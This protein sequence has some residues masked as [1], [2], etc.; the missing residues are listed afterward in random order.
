[1]DAKKMLVNT[2]GSGL[3]VRKTP[4][5]KDSLTKLT[6]GTEVVVTEEWS[7]IRYKGG[8]AW[9]SRDYLIDAPLSKKEE[10]TAFKFDNNPLDVIKI[11]QRFGEDPTL[12]KRWGLKG[13]HGLDLKTTSPDDPKGNKKVYAVLPGTVLEARRNDNNGN[14]VRLVHDRGD[15]TVYLHLDSLKVVEGQ[16]I[17]AG[18]VIGIA[19]NTGFSHGP[20]LHFGYRAPKFKIDDGYMGYVDPE[21]FL[22]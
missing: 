1:M 7:K 2:R 5:A 11:N 17:K 3:F 8:E 10:T 20:H 22:V 15:Q 12:Y 4:G 18:T 14:Y 9:V 6:D 21:S 13:H 19:G 16:V